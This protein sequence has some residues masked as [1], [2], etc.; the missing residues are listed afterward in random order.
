MTV[1]HL[2]FNRYNTDESIHNKRE[3]VRLVQLPDLA[4]TTAAGFIRHRSI[5]YVNMAFYAGPEI[6][7]Y[8]PSAFIYAPSKIINVTNGKN[9]E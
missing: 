4:V 8:F 7:D 3:F 5:A 9:Y 2:S 6:R 1:L